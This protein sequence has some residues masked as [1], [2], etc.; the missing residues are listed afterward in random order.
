MINRVV[1]TYLLLHTIFYTTASAQHKE[2]VLDRAY[3]FIIADGEIDR[4]I[5][6]DSLLKLHG[7]L[8]ELKGPLNLNAKD[9]QVDK[10][11]RII[12]ER[13]QSDSWLVMTESLDSIPMSTVP[14]PTNRFSITVFRGIT[15][16]QIETADVISRVERH[17][18]DS[19]MD[20]GIVTD[21]WFFYTYYSDD[22]WRELAA[23]P[24]VKT[25]DNA[26]K[27]MSILKSEEVKNWLTRYENNPVKEMYGSG[28]FAEIINRICLQIQYSPIFASKALQE[29]EQVK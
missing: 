7:S 13:A 4:L 14:F 12:K 22:R 26:K 11:K 23:L 8:Y 15:K 19:I 9:W 17:V 5:I 20:K 6:K 27:I 21:N 29:F 3:S 25:K 2:F 24:P 28:I 18:A 1:I 10:T 16:N